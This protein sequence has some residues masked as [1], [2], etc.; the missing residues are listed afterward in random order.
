MIPPAKALQGLD[1]LGLS[2]ETK[3]LFLSGNAERVYRL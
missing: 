2:E 3:S 1:E